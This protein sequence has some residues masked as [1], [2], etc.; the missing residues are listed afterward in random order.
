MFVVVIVVIV[1]VAVVLVVFVVVGVVVV[2]IGVVLLVVSLCVLIVDRLRVRN[3][4][5]ARCKPK[6]I[7]DEI[8]FAFCWG[9]GGDDIFI[10]T[11]S[12]L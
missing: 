2:V 4:A 8:N 11:K 9:R 3:S 1:V 12:L 5:L 7:K 6:K 10:A